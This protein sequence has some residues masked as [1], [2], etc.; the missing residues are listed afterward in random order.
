MPANQPPQQQT[1]TPWV[2]GGARRFNPPSVGIGEARPVY[3]GFVVIRGLPDFDH[4]IR[5]FSGIVFMDIITAG[6]KFFIC[7]L[8]FGVVRRRSRP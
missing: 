6:M 1:G 5:N 2:L 8:I 7:A 3:S 4:G